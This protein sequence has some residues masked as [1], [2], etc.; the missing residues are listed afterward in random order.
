V[1]ETYDCPQKSPTHH[2]Q[3]NVDQKALPQ[4]LFFGVGWQGANIRHSMKSIYELD[5]QVC[6]LPLAPT[7]S[8]FREVIQ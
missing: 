4:F 7:A 3:G 1:I 8:E 5:V 2:Q 6:S